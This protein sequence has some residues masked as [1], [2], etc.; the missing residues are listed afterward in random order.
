VSQCLS[1]DDLE[2]EGYYI[3]PTFNETPKKRKRK[4]DSCKSTRGTKAQTI[5]CELS[6]RTASEVLI[7]ATLESYNMREVL[8]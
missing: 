8:N 4:D 7:G 2:K 5:I 6:I 1:I 3:S